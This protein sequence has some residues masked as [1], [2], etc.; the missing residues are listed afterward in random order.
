VRRA[1]EQAVTDRF[2]LRADADRLIGEA[3]ASA[4]LPANA[5]AND[6]ARA[7]AQAVCAIK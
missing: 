7:R 4:V 5:A 2:L 3:Q 6:A 1:A